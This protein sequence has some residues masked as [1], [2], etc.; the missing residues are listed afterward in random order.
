MMANDAALERMRRADAAAAHG[1]KG[2]QVP[3]EKGTNALENYVTSA[4]ALSFK[5]VALE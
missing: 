2:L 5:L 3:L 1:L 4:N